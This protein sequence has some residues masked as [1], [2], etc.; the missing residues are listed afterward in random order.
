[1][2][3]AAR[4]RIGP[5]HVQLSSG[6]RPPGSAAVGAAARLPGDKETCTSAAKG[7]HLAVL[8]WAWQ[9]GCPWD[10]PT[11]TWAAKGG[12]L[13]ALQWARQHGCPWDEATC[14][15]AAEGGH[16]AVLQW[17]RWHGCPWDKEKCRAEASADFFGFRIFESD[18]WERFPE[19]SARRS[20][21]QRP[22]VHAWICEQ[23]E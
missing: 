1:M 8:Q 21:R 19:D 22:R 3:A 7:G 12:H 23:A 17:A 5:A 11:C 16:L 14:S 18:I 15:S 13:A 4:L 2:G 10:S 20:A 6:W 9:Q